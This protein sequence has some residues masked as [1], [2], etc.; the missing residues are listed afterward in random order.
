MMIQ[1]TCAEIMQ[2]QD[3][4]NEYILKPAANQRPLI[5]SLQQP[6]S[7]LSLAN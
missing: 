2:I 4:L 7:A 5:Q 6:P 3:R 1:D